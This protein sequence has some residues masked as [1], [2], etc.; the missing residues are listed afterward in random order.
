MDADTLS[1]LVANFLLGVLGLHLV[2]IV[3]F[4]DLQK[5]HIFLSIQPSTFSS[6]YF[7]QQL[8]GLECLYLQ[9]D[10]KDACLSASRF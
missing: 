10:H 6:L 9:K 5:F 7:L 8:L 3:L 4:F 1:V 2:A